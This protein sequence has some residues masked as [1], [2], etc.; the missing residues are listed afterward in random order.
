M[1]MKNP[2]DELPTSCQ[3]T[4]SNIYSVASRQYGDHKELNEVT[5]WL[6]ICNGKLYKTALSLSENRQLTLSL[7]RNPAFLEK[8]LLA[9]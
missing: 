6:D 2:P 7:K 1:R 4:F 8:P 9:I 3:K 5:S